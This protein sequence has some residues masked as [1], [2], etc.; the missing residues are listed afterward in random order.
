M[1]E[2][3]ESHKRE[4]ICINKEVLR[5]LI[6]SIAL[7]FVGYKCIKWLNSEYSP[8]IVNKTVI[9]NG[10]DS[11]F[12]TYFRGGFLGDVHRVIISNRM[13]YDRFYHNADSAFI[14]VEDLPI[15]YKFYNDT[16]FLY[17]NE[18]VTPPKYFDS[19]IKVITEDITSSDR[20]YKIKSL[21]ESS[22]KKIENNGNVLYMPY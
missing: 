1:N 10:T 14:L 4:Y 16:L 2:Q 5:L 15:F 3:L 21:Y 19:N 17:V 6:V 11:L 12:V 7:L 18:K 20:Y 8:P 22:L 13:I 9:T